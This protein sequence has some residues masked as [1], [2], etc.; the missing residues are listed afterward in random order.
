MTTAPD[1]DDPPHSVHPPLDRSGLSREI[2]RLALPAVLQNLFQTMQF[3]VDTAMIGRFGGEDASPLAAM[4]V[5]SPLCWTLTVVATI[6]SVGT[7]A[8]VSRRIGEGRR[9]AASRATATALL[10]ALGCGALVVACVLPFRVSVIEWF[11]SRLGEAGGPDVSAAAGGYVFWFVLLFPI[12]SVVVTLESAL[13]GAGESMIPFWGGVI[14]NV[15]NVLGNTVLIFGLWGAPRLGV[16]GAGLSTALAV[17]AELV[18]LVVA[19]S[20]SRRTRLS[21][22]RSAWRGI[23][24]GIARELI[25]IS[26]PAFAG[27]AI[28]H[29]GFLVYQSAIFGLSEAEIAG[30]RVAITLQS[31]GFLPAV[32]F[33][34]SAASLSGRLLGAGDRELAAEAARRNLRSGVRFALPISCVFLLGARTFASWLTDVEATI[35]A[36]TTAV[37]IGA[38]EIPFLMVTES[39]NGTLRGAGA[40]RIPL[41]ITAIGTWGIRVPLSW[42][43]AHATP[44]GLTGIWI[45]T[46]TDW[47]VR[48]AL[49]AIAVRKGTWLDEKV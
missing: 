19:L 21:V 30:H 23:D 28:F 31:L 40:T 25:R 16:E 4:G 42:T 3:F 39:L 8:V 27:A 24:R 43:L 41:R 2:W 32:G 46:V 12:R 14:T 47:I 20:F 48:G 36:A 33:T 7:T 26:T 45:A 15:T 17:G 18:F 49:T 6:T 11:T 44:L 13:R 5:A 22:P 34:I 10:L 1:G 37:R 29:A 9:G 38:L 35:D